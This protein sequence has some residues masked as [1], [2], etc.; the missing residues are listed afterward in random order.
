ML[1]HAQAM[2]VAKRF[3]P[4]AGRTLWF[5]DDGSLLSGEE[6]LRAVAAQKGEVY[7]CHRPPG[8]GAVDV[9][10]VSAAE[11]EA[12]EEEPRFGELW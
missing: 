7:A 4:S 9:A 12:G 3:N 2:E 11:L 10:R 6:T 1:S 8:G 5:A